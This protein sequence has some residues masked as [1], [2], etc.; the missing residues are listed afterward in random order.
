MGTSSKAEYRARVTAG[1]LGFHARSSYLLI[2]VLAPLEAEVVVSRSGRSV[3]VGRVGGVGNL[4]ELLALAIG[5]GDP[6]EIEC[7]GPEA[8]AA[9]ERLERIFAEGGELE[10]EGFCKID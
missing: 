7:R 5:R 3:E 8:K 10:G 1:G 6:F 2:E 9:F 4:L